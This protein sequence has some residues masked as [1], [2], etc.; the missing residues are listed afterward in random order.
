MINERNGY[1]KFSSLG[2]KTLL[3]GEC[4]VLTDACTCNMAT[5]LGLSKTMILN[6][7]QEMKHS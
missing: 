7:L 4:N 5:I 1:N 3:R 2:Q 6:L